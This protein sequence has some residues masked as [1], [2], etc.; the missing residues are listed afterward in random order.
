M[1][2]MLGSRIYFKKAWVNNL[3]YSTSF[4]FVKIKKKKYTMC[5]PLN[6]EYEKNITFEI[7]TELGRR[8]STCQNFLEYFVL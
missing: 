1:I 2:T 3:K 7:N 8:N 4:I 5:K 6:A